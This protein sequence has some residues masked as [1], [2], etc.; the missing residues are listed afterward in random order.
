MLLQPMREVVAFRGPIHVHQIGIEAGDIESIRLGHVRLWDELAGGL[1]IGEVV[2]D[3]LN[4]P[5]EMEHDRQLG[6][7]P[8]ANVEERAALSEFC[9]FTDAFE[10]QPER[11]WIPGMELG[12]L[13]DGVMPPCLKPVEDRMERFAFMFLQGSAN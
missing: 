6:A 13:Q 3:P 8:T 1:H 9:G 2:V 11:Q 7:D 10:E 12:R 5:S 4:S